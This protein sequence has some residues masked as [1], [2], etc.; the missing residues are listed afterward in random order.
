MPAPILAF[1]SPRQWEAWLAKHHASAEGIWV[2]L[3]KKSSEVPSITYAEALDGALC[4]GWIDSQK[5]AF[6]EHAWLQRFTPRRARSP[7]SKINIQHAERL[8]AAGKVKAA[9][10]R[11]IEAAKADGR[12]HAAY[13]SS[14]TMTF[15]EEFLAALKKDKKARAF[16]ETLNR[17]NLYA[18]AYRLQT[19]KTDATRARRLEAIMEKL[20]NG[21]RWH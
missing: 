11:E 15:P 17:A 8:M 21:E 13:D 18:I 19:A 4:Y 2:K 5:R 20:R 9:G 16:F 3:Y 14:K 12:W 10:L 6:D 7:W 1:T